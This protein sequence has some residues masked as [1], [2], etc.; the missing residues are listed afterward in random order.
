[1]RDVPA[2]RDRTTNVGRLYGHPPERCKPPKPLDFGVGAELE[3]PSGPP[4]VR[5]DGVRSLALAAR[6]ARSM[7]VAV[8]I[9]GDR[10][11]TVA[12]TDPPFSPLA[13]RGCSLG[14]AFR[15]WR[16]PWADLTPG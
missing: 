9:G 10:S 14:D 6:I 1:V 3:P 12:A 8:Q 13:R 11:M 5:G 15:G 16:P 7:P 2:C 4:L